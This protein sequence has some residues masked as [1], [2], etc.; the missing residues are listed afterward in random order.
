[1]RSAKL[2]FP[3]NISLLVKRATFR[4]LYFASGTSG[5]RTALLRL[6]KVCLLVDRL[7]ER[8][9]DKAGT[10]KFVDT[11]KGV[12]WSARAI[13]LVEYPNKGYVTR[14]RPYNLLRTP[15]RECLSIVY[16]LACT[17]LPRG[18]AVQ[19]KHVDKWRT[20]DS[21]HYLQSPADGVD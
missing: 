16:L 8:F 3:F 13:R 4:L 18:D 9:Q 5:R 2:R 7:I 1:M 21:N 14:D 10:Y 12:A 11:R 19:L 17:P 20:S 15:T 6:G